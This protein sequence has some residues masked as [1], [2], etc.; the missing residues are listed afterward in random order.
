MR[1]WLRSST[2]ALLVF[3]LAGCSALGT[4]G[5]LR[6]AD[7]PLTASRSLGQGD[8]TRDASLRIVI[9]G[10]D[11]DQA[12]RPSRAL[13]SY[14]RAVRVDSTNPFA[15]LALARHH[16]E[17]GSGDEASAFLDQAHLLF[18]AEG[19]LG[20]AV[21]VWGVGL[22]AWLDRSQGHDA[23]ADSRF[24]AARA[25]SSEIWVDEQLSAHELR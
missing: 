14:Q 1:I 24:D 4:T 15:Y 21:D 5:A 19:R 7:R 16:L 10:L 3:W 6:E 23:Q 9:S 20:P 8:S 11:D 25:L 17:Y 18:E 12:G 2:P 13:A 22:R